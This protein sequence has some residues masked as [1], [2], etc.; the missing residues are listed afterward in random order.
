[1]AGAI[2]GF[3]IIAVITIWS[4]CYRRRRPRNMAKTMRETSENGELRAGLRSINAKAEEEIDDDDED[5]SRVWFSRYV[6]QGVG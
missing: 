3:V 6:N 2:S 1:M 4:A 5:G